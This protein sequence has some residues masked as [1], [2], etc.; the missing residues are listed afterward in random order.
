MAHVSNCFEPHVD[1]VSALHQLLVT[2]HVELVLPGASY[3]VRMLDGRIDVQGTIKELRDRGALDE[4][5]HDA[6]I[7]AHQQ[8]GVSSAE[9]SAEALASG[10]N[11]KGPDEIAKPRKLVKDEHREAGGVKWKIYNTYLKAS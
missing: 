6:A 3:L 5:Q 4:I 1:L 8:E 10:L 7:Q 2:H 11:R 9:P